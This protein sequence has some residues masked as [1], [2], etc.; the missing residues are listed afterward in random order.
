MSRRDPDPVLS[1]RFVLELGHVQ[2]AG[3]SECTGLSLEAKFMEYREGGRN[4][5]PLKLPEVGAVGNI[6]LKRGIIPGPHADALFRWQQDVANGDFDE[7][8][9][10]NRRKT[11]PDEDIDKRCAILLQ[12]EAGQEVR[13]WKLFRA[14]PVKWSGPELKATSSEV[15]LETLELACEGLE[16]S[17]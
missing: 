13:R 2:V 15:A 16:L 1:F 17:E 10:P 4:Y 9:N 3:F 5:G 14:F 11:S 6:T 7:G 8:R 12:D